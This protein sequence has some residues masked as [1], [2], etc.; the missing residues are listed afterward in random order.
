MS[1][2]TLNYGSGKRRKSLEIPEVVKADKFRQF[3]QEFADKAG[4]SMPV[5]LPE[6]RNSGTELK[7]LHYFAAQR[8]LPGLRE[9]TSELQVPLPGTPESRYLITN[10]SREEGQITFFKSGEFCGQSPL[11]SFGVASV[12]AGCSTSITFSRSSVPKLVL[13]QSAPD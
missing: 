4:K 10:Y 1:W 7:Y 13:I 5:P 3:A 6:G 8:L 2:I 12:P 9:V 11:R